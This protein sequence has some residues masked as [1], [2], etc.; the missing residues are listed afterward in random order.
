[1]GA[2]RGSRV[3]AIDLARGIALL[4]MMLVHL[5]PAWFDQNP[6]IGDVIA[7]G[8]AAPL[9]AMLAGV[10]L[11]LVY[12]R[13]PQGA[14]SVRAT[15]IRGLILFVL[16]VSL[17]S[18]PDMPILIILAFYGLM[19]VAALPFRGLSTRTLLVLG[20]SWAII[21][22]VL[23]LWLQIESGPV[24]GGHPAFS[25]LLSPWS[26]FTG[27]VVRGA[28][29]A[30]IWFAYVLIGLAVGRLDL[31]QLR[32]ALGL[33]WAGL[34]L[35]VAT[36]AVGWIG[37]LRGVLPLEDSDGE[38]WWLLFARASYPFE[39]ATWSEL[40][41]V[42]E[43]TSRP[44]N[45]LSAIGSALLAI[46][47]CALAVRARRLRPILAP[48]LAAGT[49]T[50]TLYVAHVLWTWLTRVSPTAGPNEWMAWGSYERWAIQVVT[51]CAFAWLWQR[52]IGRGPLE[53]VV[54]WF[55][56]ARWPRQR[57]PLSQEVDSQRYSAE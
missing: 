41:R 43:H 8:R 54:R 47:L 21:A 18:L 23:L 16:G 7:A 13:D 30:G 46:G 34:G 55:S 19:I 31:K 51:L 45:V 53:S 28:Y 20:L 32:I 57:D 38:R 29:P 40:W 39:P 44:L 3:D 22:P 12:R 24:G 35:V 14:G 36:L 49:M 48:L 42:G 11:T 27:L 6:P 37:I 2:V 9:F 33:V 50:L 56:L 4:G 15:C 10:S 5:G 25:D 1:M 52:F 17:G 26:L